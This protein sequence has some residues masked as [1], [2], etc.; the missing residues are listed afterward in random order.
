MSFGRYGFTS[1][2]QREWLPVE[3][4][5]PTMVFD[6][7]KFDYQTGFSPSVTLVDALQYFVK[8]QQMFPRYPTTLMRYGGTSSSP[9]TPVARLGDVDV[10]LDARTRWEIGAR[11]IDQLKDRTLRAVAS[12]RVAFRRAYDYSHGSADTAQLGQEMRAVAAGRLAWPGHDQ[13]VNPNDIVLMITAEVLETFPDAELWNRHFPSRSP[14]AIDL[15]ARRLA[16]MCNRRG[17]NLELPELTRTN[18]LAAAWHSL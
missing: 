14:E 6:I 12:N 7:G 2:P 3:R 10:A 11:V 16:E 8:S 13:E 17:V 1:V 15:V 4:L 9:R 5:T 18:R